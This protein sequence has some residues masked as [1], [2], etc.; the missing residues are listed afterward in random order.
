MWHVRGTGEM[1][2]GLWWGD[3]RER[4]PLEDLGAE[5]RIILKLVFKKWNGGM[6]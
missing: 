1:H 5:G 6:D 2:T 3:L 4:D